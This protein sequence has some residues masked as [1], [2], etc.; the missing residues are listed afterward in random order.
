MT[1]DPLYIPHVWPQGWGATSATNG[2]GPLL[3]YYDIR[4]Q[5]LAG[6]ILQGLSVIGLAVLAVRR[7]F[8]PVVAPL[9]LVVALHAVFFVYGLFGSAGYARYLVC[10]APPLALVTL[11]GWNAAAAWLA[12]LPRAATAAAGALV[13]A[14]ALVHGLLSVDRYGSSRDALAVA[15]TAAWL[16]AHPRPIRQLVFSQ[17]YMPIALGRDPAG[18]P[19]LGQDVEQNVRLLRATPPG[20][21]AFWDAK[22]GPLFHRVGPTE[23]VR[24]GFERLYAASY[25]LRPRLPA[26]RLLALRWLIPAADWPQPYRQELYLF[27]KPLR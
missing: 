24:A 13:L 3:H 19:A 9:L 15:D 5:I 18:R 23:L 22:T 2:T 16:E 20:T 21:L 4:N 10:V 6:P 26:E 11:A 12:R 7:R 17:A 25:D 1:G 14:A 8:L 27:Y